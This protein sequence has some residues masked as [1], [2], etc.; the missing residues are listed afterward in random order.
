MISFD[1]TSN[2]YHDNPAIGSGDIRRMVTSPQLFRDGMDGICDRKSAALLF[3][4]A[5]HMRLL[6]PVAFAR[7]AAIKPE[8]MSF[9]TLEGKA[10]KAANA[11]KLIV[12]WDDAA[13]LKR[14]HDRMPDEVRRIFAACKTEVTVRTK[15]AGL[16][17]QCRPDLWDMQGRRFYDLK[18]IDDINGID[19]AIWSHRYD[20]QLRFYAQ[21]IAAETG[22]AL[23][24]SALIFAEKSAPYRWRVVELDLDYQ[25]LADAAIKEALASIA[26]RM[27][28]GCWN[29]QSDLHD[30][31]TP[32]AWMESSIPVLDDDEEAA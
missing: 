32:P 8:G 23:R 31:A 15:L 17:V 20:V 16:D 5:S 26:A 30:I 29:D 10:W 11:G 7:T 24:Q 18:T 14:M 12:S 3:G 25:A 28:S 1:E 6:E 4:I 21:V 9:A 13:H 22:Q 19:K 27:K 2:A